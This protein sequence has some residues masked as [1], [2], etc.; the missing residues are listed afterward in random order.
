MM[1][2]RFP[3]GAALLLTAHFRNQPHLHAGRSVPTA[4]KRRTVS[5]FSAAGNRL[6]ALPIPIV[7]INLWNAESGCLPAESS[8]TRKQRAASRLPGKTFTGPLSLTI[9]QPSPL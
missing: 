1:Q 5:P 8:G 7:F 3:M 4:A 6:P 2:G 9:Y